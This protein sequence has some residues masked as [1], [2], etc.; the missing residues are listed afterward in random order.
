MVI[1]R[2]P[3]TFEMRERYR[4]CG[5]LDLSSDCP[6]QVRGAI[7]LRV[8]DEWQEKA[9]VPVRAVIDIDRRRLD[10]AAGDESQAEVALEP[11]IVIELLRRANAVGTVRQEVPNA[12]YTMPVMYVRIDVQVRGG[13][14]LSVFRPQQYDAT[15]RA[16]SGGPLNA[17]KVAYCG[18]MG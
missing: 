1:D 16:T 12:R 15:H 7:P 9:V 2:P 3:M 14:R 18:G 8:T 10:N 13:E 17:P 4:H 11:A 5:P 6:L